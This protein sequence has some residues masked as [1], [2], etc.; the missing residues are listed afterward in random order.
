MRSAFLSKR[1][2]ALLV[3]KIEGSWPTNIVPKI[4]T[5]KEYY[6]DEEGSIYKSNGFTAVQVGKGKH[7]VPFLG[8]LSLLALFPSVTV[9][10][11]AVRFVCNG[12]KVTRPGITAFDNFKEGNVVVIKD[13]VHGKPLAIGLA[14]IDSEKAV[15]EQ[16]GYVIQTLHYISDKIWEAH[17]LINV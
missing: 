10:M 1:D 8:D 17:K 5:I 2:T 9:D 4:K 12:A 14:L 7:I 6:V 15:K 3:K 13:Q 11:G 16:K